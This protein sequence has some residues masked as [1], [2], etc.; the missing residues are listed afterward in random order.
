[1]I[2]N[3]LKRKRERDYTFDWN[4]AFDVSSLYI[5]VKESSNLTRCINKFLLILFFVKL[6]ERGYWREIAI[7]TLS[8]R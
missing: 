4:T 2:V 1:M 8:T 5:I 3:D 6:V 7:Y